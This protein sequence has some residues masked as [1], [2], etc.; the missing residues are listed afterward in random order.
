VSSP[1]A[2]LLI[3]G[4]QGMEEKVQ[5]CRTAEQI[6]NV[7]IVVIAAT[8]AVHLRIP[9]QIGNEGGSHIEDEPNQKHFLYCTHPIPDPIRF[10]SQSIAPFSG[11]F[12]TIITKK[13]ESCE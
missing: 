12:T 9:K 10:M 2:F 7:I 8:E 4:Q 11:M 1:F 3:S 5:K 13:P 6:I